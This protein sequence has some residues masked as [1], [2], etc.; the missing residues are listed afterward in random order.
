[1]SPSKEHEHDNVMYVLWMFI[2]TPLCGCFK[3]M[4][5]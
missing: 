5:R 1:M 4:I 2:G 3:F